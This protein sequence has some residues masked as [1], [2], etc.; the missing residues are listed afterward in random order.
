MFTRKK[1]FVSTFQ[2]ELRVLNKLDESLLHPFV[3]YLVSAPWIKWWNEQNISVLKTNHPIWMDSFRKFREISNTLHLNLFRLN[4]SKLGTFIIFRDTQVSVRYWS[5]CTQWRHN[6][7]LV[8]KIYRLLPKSLQFWQA[9]HVII[10]FLNLAHIT[11]IHHR[12]RRFC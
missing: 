5:T 9:R 6:M 10:I 11:Y 3:G 8:V 12:S 7:S 4:S 1:Y 2:W